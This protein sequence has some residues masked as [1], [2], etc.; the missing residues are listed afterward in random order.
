MTLMDPPYLN[1]GCGADRRDGYTG[2]DLYAAPGVDVVHNLDFAPWPWSDGQVHHILARHVFE[3][4]NDPVLFMA[5]CWRV[6]RP[7]GTLDIVTPHWK[8][9][10]AYTDPTHKRFPTEYTFDYWVPG[11]MLR[12]HHGQAYKG[13][14]FTYASAPSIIG[15]ELHVNLIKTLE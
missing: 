3:H 4:V 14:T 6:L 8:S 5:E 9:R 15:G 13:V 1:L 7:G 10:D 2:V 11:K 12:Q